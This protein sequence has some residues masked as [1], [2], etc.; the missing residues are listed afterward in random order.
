[1]VEAEHFSLL[2]L[3]AFSRNVFWALLSCKNSHI[4]NHASLA[5]PFGSQVGGWFSISTK[6][7]LNLCM[8]LANSTRPTPLWSNHQ[9]S[10]FISFG[11]GSVTSAS[12]YSMTTD[13]VDMME[14]SFPPWLYERFSS[15]DSRSDAGSVFLCSRATWNLKSSVFRRPSRDSR[16]ASLFPS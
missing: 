8:C 1:M 15:F 3:T 13:E 10:W 9:F 16:N 12:L 6:W 11:D 14:R 7:D 2:L 4:F 5:K